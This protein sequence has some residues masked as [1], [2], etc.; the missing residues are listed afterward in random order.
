MLFSLQPAPAQQAPDVKQVPQKQEEAESKSAQENK[1]LEL[2]L[3]GKTDTA[4]GE[5]RR[6]ENVQFNLVDNNALKELNVRLGTSATIIGEFSPSRNYFGSEFGNSPI[7]M[8]TIPS[9]LK[10]GTHGNVR[11]SHLNSIFSARS[12]FQVGDVKPAHDNDYGLSFGTPLWKG[13]NFYLEGDQ[14]KLRGSVN[15]NVLVPKPD[16]RTPLTTDPEASRDRGA[17]PGCIPG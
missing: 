17:L 5:S 1:R 2:N 10:S 8:L 15:G 11:Y 14:G 9:A 6:N 13:S 12:F 16:E 3:L 7:Q 4:A